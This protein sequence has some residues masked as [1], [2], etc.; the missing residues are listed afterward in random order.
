MQLNNST[1]E[2]TAHLVQMPPPQEVV[3]EPLQAAEA[4]LSSELTPEIM[5]QVTQEAQKL[6]SEAQQQ[7]I[8]QKELDSLYA[9]AFDLYQT[10]CFE[11]AVDIFRLLCFYEP[12]KSK[13]WIGLGGA[14]QHTKNHQAALAA[15]GMAS[16]YDPLNPA[17]RFYAAHSLIDIQDLPMAL[18][19]AKAAIELC[20]HQTDKHNIKSRAT[21]LSEALQKQLT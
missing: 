4:L 21:T 13:N 18:A 14:L 3:S 5:E 15:F 19:S 7:G 10:E 8:T 20:N 6:P 11:Q 16:F 17:P 1:S 12:Q 2:L 9:L